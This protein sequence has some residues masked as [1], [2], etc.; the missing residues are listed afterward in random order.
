MDDLVVRCAWCGRVKNE[1]GE[2]EKRETI[3]TK[4]ITH[5]ICEECA[6]IAE[7]EFLK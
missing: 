1:N 6:E 5:G 3:P 4:K 7:K 2:W